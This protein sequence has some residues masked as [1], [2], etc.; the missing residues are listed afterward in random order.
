M[1]DSY[2]LYTNREWCRQ[3]LPVF[4]PTNQ[5]YHARQFYFSAVLAYTQ[6]LPLSSTARRTTVIKEVKL[7]IMQ[8]CYC[9]SIFSHTFAIF[10]EE[11]AIL[12]VYEESRMLSKGVK[13]VRLHL[14]S[15]RT[16]VKYLQSL[17]DHKTGS[18]MHC[19]NGKQSKISKI[20]PPSLRSSAVDLEM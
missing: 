18:S 17:H 6:P 10:K 5:I 20:T 8:Q 13:S 16:K 12:R 14:P 9:A 4:L 3:S 1:Y 7:N 2:R 15:S 19:Q 11:T